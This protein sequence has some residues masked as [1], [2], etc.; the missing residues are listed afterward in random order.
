ML[1][2]VNKRTSKNVIYKPTL[3]AMLTTIS[4]FLAVAI[5]GVLIYTKMQKFWMRWE[6]WFVG[7][8]VNF[9]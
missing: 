2:F 8:L 9:V 3:K 4:V 1:E 5:T 6:V 7:S